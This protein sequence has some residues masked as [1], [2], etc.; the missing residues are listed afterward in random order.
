M[1]EGWGNQK[2]EI[3]T[4]EPQR[5]ANEQPEWW[6]GGRTE[7][8]E[9]RRQELE[10]M[11]DSGY[12]TLDPGFSIRTLRAAHCLSR[13][14]LPHHLIPRLPSLSESLCKSR[15]LEV[16]FQITI[17]IRFALHSALSPATPSPS[18]F[19]LGNA[20]TSSFRE[21]AHIS[22]PGKRKA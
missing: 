9:Y 15:I 4:S 11:P 14:G 8:K 10:W 17:K 16:L 2:S 20:C 18:L 7:N 1:V 13:I 6:N 5:S 3:R 12:W 21:Q 22:G 19:I